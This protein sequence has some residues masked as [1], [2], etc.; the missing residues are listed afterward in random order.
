MKITGGKFK[1]RQLPQ[2]V[3]NG[4]RPTASK[5]REAVFNIIGPEISASS[6]LDLYA[7]TGAV[8]FEALGRGA[9]DVVFVDRDIEAI[10]RFVKTHHFSNCRIIKGGV[11]KVLSNIERRQERFD[12]IYVDPP[13]DSAEVDQVMPLLGHIVNVAGLII[14]EHFHKK[15]L[16]T[17]YG[18]IELIKT[19]RYGDTILS[20]YKGNQL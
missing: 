17:D 13:Y 1:G 19:Y 9:K 7:G 6:F 2:K 5:V 20:L 3:K 16:L 10:E 18:L 11:L 8:G 12:F 4:V 15:A 14:V